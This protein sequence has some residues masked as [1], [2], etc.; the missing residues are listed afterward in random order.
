MTDDKQ[1]DDGQELSDNP[2]SDDI[3]LSSDIE[4][5][6]LEQYG[7][8]VKTE[9]EDIL[10]QEETEDFNLSDLSTE[11]SGDESLLTEEEEE[12]LEGEEA[13]ELEGEEKED[14]EKESTETP[15][16]EEK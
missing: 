9:P 8:W 1:K 5:E 15:T 3:S 2:I 4:N 6:E 13:A 10:D 7:V 11:E 14:K 16:S 12:L